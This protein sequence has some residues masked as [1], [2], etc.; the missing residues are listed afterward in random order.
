MLSSS[1]AHSVFWFVLLLQA[2]GKS[3]EERRNLGSISY[4]EGVNL[5][6]RFHALYK[7]DS[8]H[9]QCR[10]EN[11]GP[12]ILPG[13]SSNPNTYN[14]GL[15]QQLCDLDA[16]FT[17][18]LF[19]VGAPITFD[20]GESGLGDVAD[21]DECLMC[22]DIWGKIRPGGAELIYRND[23]GACSCYE[24]SDNFG[25]ALKR[26][27]YKSIS[28]RNQC[29]NFKCFQPPPPVCHDHETIFTSWMWSTC[30]HGNMYA[31]DGWKN[32]LFGSGGHCCCQE[33]FT[34]NIFSQTCETCFP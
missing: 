15:R 21:E 24:S 30:N 8:P 28:S 29:A 3:A 4:G 5:L 10:R 34:Y 7:P 22:I 33:G 13:L 2:W 12:E 27:G 32:W 11:L 6:Q 9:Y 25:Q 26:Y 23:I 1:K 18:A 19:P 14:P 31:C 16:S 17:N 20:F